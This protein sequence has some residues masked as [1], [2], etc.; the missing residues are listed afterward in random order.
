LTS[1]IPLGHLSGINS[2]GNSYSYDANGN[3]TS[4]T[5]AGT[6]YTFTFDRENR[7]T[8]VSGGTVS[9]SFVYDADGNR[10]K[11]TIG[12]VTTVYIGGVYEY[13]GGATTH[14]YEGHA[15]RR[16]GYAINNGIFYLL[17]DHLGSNRDLINQDGTRNGRNFY[18]PYGGNRAGVPYNPRSTKRFTGQYHEQ[19]LPGEEG[20]SYYGARWYDAQLGRFVSADTMVP[21]ATNPQH[22]NRY[23]YGVGNPLRHT[24]PSGNFPWDIVDAT[25]WLWSAKDFIEQ[26]SW[27]NFGWLALDTVSLVPLLPSSGWFRRGSEVILDLTNKVW[28]RGDDVERV[29]DIAKRSVPKTR[30]LNE[31]SVRSLETIQKYGI[32]PFSEFPRPRKPQGSPV[33]HLVEKRFFNQLGF[34]SKEEATKRI[35]SIQL[36]TAEHTRITAALQTAIHTGEDTTGASV[37]Q[38]WNAHK[39]VYERLGHHDWLDLIWDVYFQH[40]PNVKK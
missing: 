13:Q 12:G 16:T 15:F 33:H 10:I 21:D 34:A 29:I 28:R 32:K 31:I 22:L 3:Q 2:L 8:A 7:L 38:I 23:A 40:L 5:L 24:D 19:D 36:T 25:F 1:A 11:G 27:G 26:P 17:Q 14:Y 37:Q 39:V 20:L 30:T 6:V 4:R 18:F 35:L 9:A